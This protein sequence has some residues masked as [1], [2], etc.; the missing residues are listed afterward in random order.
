[1]FGNDMNILNKI[2]SVR[3]W[4]L[5]NPGRLGLVPTM[6]FLHEGHL[7]LVRRMQEITERVAVSLFVNPT[8]FNHPD[9]LS[10]YPR[11]EERDLEMLRTEG[12]SLVF[13]PSVEEMYGVTP[14]SWVN[15]DDL[16]DK[17]EGAS[18][19]GHFR[20]VCTVVA[21]LF[22]IL[23]PTVAIFGEK[24]FQQLR[25]IET[26]VQGLSLPV[27][28]E[29]GQ[30]VRESDGLAMS[31]RNVR[32]SEAGRTSAV[33]LSRALKACR[34]QVAAGV[35]DSAT[36]IGVASDTIGRESRVELEYFTIVDEETLEPVAKV[37]PT[38]RALLA[39]WVDGV[40][41]IDTDRLE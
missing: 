13:M 29:R 41:L 30:L 27:L 28:I 19:P 8:Q 1:M 25:V 17:L 21:K 12:V 38:S 7:S 33:V 15:V 10:R 40:R 14:K 5:E 32:L 23:T 4:R 2:S 24:D 34:L 9:D 16:G 22:G 39:A 18:R 26:M 20:G 6:G 35:R 36:L 3:Q 37:T 11:N 31:S